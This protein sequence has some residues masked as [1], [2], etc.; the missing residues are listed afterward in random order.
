VTASADTAPDAT[1]HVA[2]SGFTV[3]LHAAL[4]L[5]F[6]ITGIGLLLAAY[7]GVAWPTAF[8]GSSLGEYLTYGRAMPAALNA[9][10]YG[11][12]TLGLLGA[13][14]YFVPRLAG[15]SLSMGG[16]AA[17]GGVV[18]AVGTASGV[19]SILA[20]DGVG[21]RLLE[22]PWYS[23]VLILL[24]ALVA[25]L[26]I[27]GT[28]RRSEAVG[29][30]LWYALAAPWWLFLAHAA[31]VVPGLTGIDAELQ[32]AFTS[33]AVLGMWVVPAAIG[34]GY[35]LISEQV[36]EAEFH[37]RLGRIGF[38]SIGLLWAWT[39]ARTL[40]YGPTDD[41]L[42][43]IPVLFAAGLV[44]AAIAVVTDLAW[45]VRGRLDEVG[46]STSLGL[47]A[48]GTMLFL[49]VPGHML[50]QSLRGPSAVIRFTAWEQ[51]FDL[52]GLIGA[53]TLWT[54][55]LVGHVVSPSAFR[56]LG[57]RLG[58]NAML[59]GALFAVG[60]RWIAGLQQGYT[61]LGGVESQLYPNHGE[62]FVNTVD[63]LAGTD[64]LTFIGLAVFGAGA[65]LF[66]AGLGLPMAEERDIERR[67]PIWIF[68]VGIGSLIVSTLLPTGFTVIAVFVGVIASAVGLA[69][70]LVAPMVDRRP[71]PARVGQDGPMTTERRLAGGAILLGILAIAAGTLLP[72]DFTEAALY[73]GF[74]LLL[75]GFV[76]LG[77]A[78]DRSS[79]DGV[80]SGFAWPDT[81]EPAVIRRGAVAVFALAVLVVFIM[82][83][84]DADAEATLLADSSRSLADGSQAARGL[85]VYVSE[86]CWYCHTQQVRAVVTDL[87]LGP[88]STAGDYVYDPAGTLGVA[89]L[90][91]DLAH[92]GSREPTSDPEWVA[93]HLADPRVE[94]P[95][96]T[97]PAYG[98]LT[99]DDLTAL[100]AYI[101]GLE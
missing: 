59:I 12:L 63:V 50:L 43:T 89:R 48:I 10:V 84:Y 100:A 61:W 83:A 54:A 67:G 45:A 52:L 34:L 41:W 92:A 33:T 76:I 90:G 55:A 58:R 88:V 9:F 95:W 98:H 39:A 77:A 7:A 99:G 6:F 35:A 4:A 74:G 25:A 44:V 2:V 29:V 80:G 8:E 46:R 20:G 79:F 53:Y 37:P 36:P 66:V 31:G 97:M 47:Y 22:M 51:A 21:G 18:L 40:Q 13:L 30:P 87:G 24:G 94:R 49:L 62:G 1:A 91:P 69:V 65:L 64:I 17:V 5:V 86:G 68:V 78:R 38:W 82:P 3:R 19:G 27:T 96:S 81:E 72:V 32:S 101:A 26:A 75:V 56:R 11:W 15:G 23:D 28:I 14:Y 70:Y 73:G 71:H 57:G 42:E 85:E 16:A 60:T 93:A